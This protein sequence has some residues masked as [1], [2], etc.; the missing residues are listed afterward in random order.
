M[1]ILHVF[2]AVRA[3]VGGPARG[4]LDLCSALARRGH[5]VTL[6][7]ADAAEVPPE[8]R[9]PDAPG[10]PRVVELGG[11]VL[12]GAALRA[13]GVAELRPLVQEADVVH[14][15]GVWEY[16]NIQAA[17]LARA[18]GKPYVITVRGMLDDWAMSRKPAKKR[19]YL[20][21]F[22]KRWLRN[23]TAV[24]FTAEGEL[25]QSRR[26]V[27]LQRTVVIPNLLDLSPYER[28]PGPGM[29]E[30]AFAFVRDRRA[31]SA[32]T[33]LFLSRIHTGKGLEALIEAVALLKRGGIDVA[34][35]VAGSGETGYVDAMKGMARRLGLVEHA[36]FAFLG[37]VSGATKLSLYEACDIFALP[38]SQENFGFV[39]VEALACR[40]PVVTTKGA[41]IWPELER[42]GGVR[43]AEPTGEAF[44]DALGELLKGRDRLPEMGGAGRRWVFD[45]LD[46]E[47]VIQRFEE[48]YRRAASPG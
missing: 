45:D 46:P 23:A 36:D 42:S 5:S 43:I 14:L 44:A 40:T 22:G 10:R 19:L 30:E 28:L 13:Q 35:A 34:L 11:G 6:A 29:A 27:S 31:R 3:E 8:W 16:L 20:A 12:P 24:H 38:T 26:R 37:F 48:M 47:K 21:L 18:A 15:H 7:T 39:L 41:D 17:R 25:A 33:I 1:R 9:A 2:L 32:P 4:V